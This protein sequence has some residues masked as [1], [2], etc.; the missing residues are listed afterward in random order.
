MKY[1]VNTLLWTA[2][3][4]VSHLPL[5]DALKRHGF[6]GVEIARFDFADFPSA[7][8]RRRLE[9]TGL[10]CTFCSALTGDLNLVSG[11]AAVRRRAREFLLAGIQT[12]AEIGARMFSGP[13]CAPVGYK[14]GR[15]RS[16]DEWKWAVEE[17]QSLGP[18]LEQ[19]EVTLAIEPLNRFETYFLNTAADAV[20][21]SEAVGNVR[22]GILM[23][24]FHANIEEKDLGRAL[25]ECGRHLKHV[26]T[27]ENDRGIPGSGHVEWN[28]LKAALEE[29]GYDGWLVIESFA[30][31]IPEIAAATCI[32]RDLAPSSEAIAYE[33]LAF[34]KQ[35]AKGGRAHPAP[36][37]NPAADVY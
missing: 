14:P 22:V 2:A 17:L 16:G 20:A 10:E 34:L 26:H 15:R 12:T 27:C 18:A 37:R 11:D 21:L 5:F 30:G 9:N 1:G 29:I 3:F 8:V 32:W 13:F 35:L 24:T 19:Y 33:G 25:R 6:D 23:D 7:A 4:D 36:F 28:A 31:G